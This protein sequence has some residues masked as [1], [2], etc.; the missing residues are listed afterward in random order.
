MCEKRGY[1]ENNAWISRCDKGV[2][3]GKRE[4]SCKVNENADDK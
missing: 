4:R 1:D 3:E 2:I